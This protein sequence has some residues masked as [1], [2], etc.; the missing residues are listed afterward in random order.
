MLGGSAAGDVRDREIARAHPHRRSPQLRTPPKV[1]DRTSISTRGDKTSQKFEHES[2]TSTGAAFLYFLGNRRPSA[3]A[4]CCVHLF[5][6][7][8]IL[9]LI[10]HLAHK[11]DCAAN[12]LQSFFTKYHFQSSF[13]GGT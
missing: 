6:P 5:D 8:G 3:G 2:M 1:N 12:V 4:L 7:T 13:D 9:A 11:R 10:L